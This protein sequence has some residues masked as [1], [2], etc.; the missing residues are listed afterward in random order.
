MNL[1]GPLIKD[2]VQRPLIFALL[3]VPKD[4]NP[5]FASFLLIQ[6]G[7]D[8]R[9][10][11]E[12]SLNRGYVRMMEKKMETTIMGYIGYIMGSEMLH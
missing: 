11:S 3:Q 4:R 5:V 12:R 6:R 10:L 1:R 9:A 2:P 7:P 8:Q